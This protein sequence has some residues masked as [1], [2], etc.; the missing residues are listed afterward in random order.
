MKTGTIGLCFSLLATLTLPV[1]GDTTTYYIIEENET[2][3]T[4]IP[5]ATV[6]P[7]A[8]DAWLLG[9]DTG[10]GVP[11]TPGHYDLVPEPPGE[12]LGQNVASAVGEFGTP[13]GTDRNI[14]V[15]SG[16]QLE[17]VDKA[18]N[19]PSPPAGVT[20]QD[21]FVTDPNGGVHSVVLIDR[22]P[23]SSSTAL[24][25]AISWF[26]ILTIARRFNPLLI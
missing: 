12:P 15:L 1:L 13:F 24:L 26:G 10:W 3:T 2:L 17:S 23:D 25:L 19:I 18:L 16:P 5:N 20:V 7:G 4:T 11:T 22:V 6:T 9:L 14:G 8:P 21:L